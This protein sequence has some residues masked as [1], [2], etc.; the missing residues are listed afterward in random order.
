MVGAQAVVGGSRGQQ[1]GRQVG[2]DLPVAFASGHAATP[3]PP[4][5]LQVRNVL[6]RLFRVYGHI[7]H[8]HFRWAQA[9][10]LLLPR[11]EG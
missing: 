7:Y 9:C 4:F 2:I 1:A 6:K 5:C 11:G 10:R 8:S 3:S